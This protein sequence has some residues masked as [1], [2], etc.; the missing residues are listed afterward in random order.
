MLVALASAAGSPGV[1]TTALALALHWPRPVVLV[2]ADPCGSS[3]L[4][5]GYFRGQLDQPGLVDLV[6]A[7]RSDLLGDAVPRLLFELEGSNASV[8][9]GLR[10]H[11]QSAG[12]SQ[13][14]PPLLEVLHGLDP[15]ATDVIVDAGRLGLPGWPQ[16]LVMGADAVLLL[17]RSDLP[18]LAG[19][20]SWAA[21]LAREDAPGHTTRILLVGESRPYGAREVGKTLGVPVL[22]SI[23][24]SPELARVYSHGRPA[25]DLPWWRRIGRNSG[26]ERKAFEGSAY[27]RS[28]QAV[29]GAIQSLA[30]STAPAPFRSVLAQ[31]GVTS[32]RGT[33]A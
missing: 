4:L 24:W 14:W 7:Q 12:A 5:A 6:I 19:A 13:L 33:T 16:P 22:G 32:E 2:E 20:R 27:V 17:T 26:A 25:P 21:T 11:E 10:S 18:G 29:T 23:E 15:A 31:A 28:I 8:L 9:F 30:D 1:T 3:G